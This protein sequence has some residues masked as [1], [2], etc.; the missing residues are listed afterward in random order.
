MK[1]SKL[2][3]VLIPV[4]LLSLTSCKQSKEYKVI[5]G[6]TQ[7]TT[8]H[9]V[10]EYASADSLNNIVDSILVAI[11]NSLSVYNNKSIISAV[12]R[13]EEVA[14]DTLFINVFNRSVEITKI[15]NGAFDISAAPFF[16]IWGF[17][18]KNKESVTDQKLDSI[19]AFTGMDKIK[20]ENGKVVKTDPR[21][22]INVNAIAQGYTADVIAQEFDRRGIENYL[23]EIGGE[24]MCKGKNSRGELWTIA[25]DKPVDGNNIPGQDV[26]DIVE[27][28]VRGLATSG[29]YRKYYEE[30]GEKFSH[31]I[32]PSTGKPVK[33]N[34]LSATVI[35]KDAM[36]ADAM[37]TVLMVVGLDKAKE[38]LAADATMDAYLVYSEQGVF[39][40]YKTEGVQIRQ[41]KK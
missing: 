9:I 1:F 31:T 27:L 28:T 29:N 26:Q 17:G 38:I 13:N 32:D 2:L 22:T 21:V 20:I 37:A 5:D 34:L 15:S 36:T 16:D 7:G 4:V 8:Y 11:D 24:I 6:F 23:V 30:N 40:V 18:F 25:I 35:A 33:H 12:N 10:Y 3:P 14:L 41:T 19:K 39:K